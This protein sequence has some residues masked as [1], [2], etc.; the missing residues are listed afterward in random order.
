MRSWEESDLSVLTNMRH[1]CQNP[2]KSR[3]QVSEKINGC[4]GMSSGHAFLWYCGDMMILQSDYTR[5]HCPSRSIW[6]RLAWHFF[7]QPFQVTKSFFSPKCARSYATYLYPLSVGIFAR[8]PPVLRVVQAGAFCRPVGAVLGRSCDLVRM[9][10]SW[11]HAQSFHTS[12][13][14]KEKIGPKSSRHRG[15]KMHI[16]FC[17]LAD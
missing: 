15:P 2:N 12:E 3:I 16:S 5:C 4:S 13:I 8:C 17:H 10:L 7:Q 6:R 14:W 9:N 1:L 11:L